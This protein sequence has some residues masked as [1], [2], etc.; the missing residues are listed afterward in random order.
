MPKGTGKF[1]AFTGAAP[2]KADFSETLDKFYTGF[3]KGRELKLKEQMLKAKQSK[4]DQDHAA[5]LRE[6]SIKNQNELAKLATEIPNIDTSGVM[7]PVTLKI[8]QNTQ[9]K[10]ADLRRKILTSNPSEQAALRFEI[11]DLK[12]S[13]EK[14][15]TFSS[16]MQNL[17]T[18]Y[19]DK[20]G[21][22]DGYSAYGSAPVI[23]TLLDALKGAS[24][25][26]DLT[27]NPDG[28]YNWGDKM[29]I[30]NLGETDMKLAIKND[31]GEIVAENS[32]AQI[33]AMLQGEFKPKFNTGKFLDDV[34]KRI[35]P[36]YTGAYTKANGGIEFTKGVNRRTTME[37]LREYINEQLTDDNI[38]EL[39]A[40]D[41]V[42]G[43][44][45]DQIVEEYAQ[46][47]YKQMQKNYDQRLQSDPTLNAELKKN[48]I[49]ER[50]GNINS[51]LAGDENVMKNLK[52]KRLA[53]VG[54]RG[55]SGG[56]ITD[57]RRSGNLFT[58]FVQDGKGDN[59][60]KDSKTYNMADPND[61]RKLLEVV[62][63]AFGDVAGLKD[64]DPNQI[65]GAIDPANVQALV[66]ENTQKLGNDFNKLTSTFG[67]IEGDPADSE[68]EDALEP[69]KETLESLGITYEVS[70]AYSIGGGNN[71]L[72]IKDLEGNEI[73]DQ[74]IRNKDGK[75]YL[76]NVQN[77]LGQT[78]G[79]SPQQ[80]SG[81]QPG[82][83]SN[84]R[85][86]KW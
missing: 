72:I 74:T 54:V 8:F 86:I 6:Q 10:I 47:A 49:N 82:T 58:F 14:V 34:L 55:V 57:V 13:G 65:F 9:G 40:T 85:K 11:D 62:N 15:N 20:L 18:N 32:F 3:E 17:F 77:W 56:T 38:Q 5:K 25:I 68:M 71:E 12:R 53:D 70:T 43:T 76:Q 80:A 59:V 81:A 46:S 66:T 4:A 22:P 73:K 60:R 31:K 2:V 52:N 84:K 69:F 63:S 67:A 39:I 37:G 29:V 21:K 78:L 24:D 45:R 1:G 26:K 79:I 48:S 28:S 51:V 35:K 83:T 33:P 61:Q 44:N 41:Q 30:K 23:I 36:S 16:Q 64:V 7:N 50:V 75:Q 42:D 27:Q 19:I